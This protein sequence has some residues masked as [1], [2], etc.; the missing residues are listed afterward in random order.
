MFFGELSII[1]E[2]G[3]LRYQARSKRPH[4]TPRDRQWMWL[5]DFNW[6]EPNTGEV[7]LRLWDA[8]HGLEPGE[9]VEVAGDVG[10][11][12]SDQYWCGP[13]T[14]VADHVVYLGEIEVR[15]LAESRFGYRMPGADEPGRGV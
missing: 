8:R 9:Y 7:L 1:T 10:A 3:R 14:E 4:P 13:I 2:R 5:H 11:W 6:A 12:G 15:R